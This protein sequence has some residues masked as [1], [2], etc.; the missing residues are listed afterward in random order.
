[1]WTDDYDILDN[2]GKDSTPANR[3]EWEGGPL[4][5]PWLMLLG[6]LVIGVDVVGAMAS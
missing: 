4:I 1:M 3:N 6:L 2:D 5:W